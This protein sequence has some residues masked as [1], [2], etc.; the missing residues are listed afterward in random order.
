MLNSGFTVI[1]CQIK[2]EKVRKHIETASISFDIFNFPYSKEL[3]PKNVERLKRLFRT[4]RGCIPGDL[5][6][7]IP[8]VISED[9]LQKCLIFSGKIVNELRL[10]SSG[11]YTKFEFPSRI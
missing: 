5:Q 1:T 2:A 4:E 9:Y 3:D 8:A 7:R 10:E 6:N 11:E